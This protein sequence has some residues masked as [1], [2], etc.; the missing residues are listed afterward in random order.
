MEKHDLTEPTL[1][2]TFE[3]LSVL[4]N[5]KL[6]RR[7]T[8]KIPLFKTKREQVIFLERNLTTSLAPE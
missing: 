1:N 7:G 2:I 3:S 6:Q 8:L 4:N 5:K